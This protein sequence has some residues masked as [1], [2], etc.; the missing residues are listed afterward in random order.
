MKTRT[1]ELASASVT[2]L[3]VLGAAAC[4][5]PSSEQRHWLGSWSSSQTAAADVWGP[6]WSTAGFSNHSVRQSFRPTIGGDRVR[7][8]LSNR[9]GDRPLRITAATVGITAGP[10]AVL[11]GTLRQLLFGHSQRTEIPAGTEQTSDAVDL[12]IP[13]LHPI[14]VTLYLADH[15]GP[16]TFH[17]LGNATSYRAVGDHAADTGG[18]SFTESSRSWYYVSDV[19]VSGT[20]SR[21]GVV[22][23]GDS[24]T[25]GAGATMDVDNR[26][27]DVLAERLAAAGESRAVLNAGIG[28]NRVVSDSVYVGQRALTRFRR[29]VLDKKGVGTVILLSGI[30][31][32]GTSELGDPRLEPSPEVTADHLI[33]EYRDLIALARAHGVRIIGGTLLP[34]KGARYYSERGEAIREAVNS[35]IRESGEFDAVADFERALVSRTDADALDPTYDSGDHLH[36]SPAGYAAMAAVIDL[37]RL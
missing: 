23:F 6:N 24:L 12:S 25:D 34:Y 35:W 11:P 29:D 37:S 18:A 14:T 8:T 16:A 1:A 32:I 10:A 19:E 30:N 17:F 7:I 33:A 13:A 9:F 2:A 4:G 31:D 5:N 36:P 26:Y 3:L 22:A 20:G 28:G 27:P 21:R 15:T